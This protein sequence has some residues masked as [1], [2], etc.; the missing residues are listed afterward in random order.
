[1][2]LNLGSGDYPLEGYINLDAKH[3]DQLFPLVPN[4]YPGD[5]IP[6]GGLTSNSADEVRASHVLE[7]FPHGQT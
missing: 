7:H 1:M 4:R 2:K 5:G 3:S 6:Q